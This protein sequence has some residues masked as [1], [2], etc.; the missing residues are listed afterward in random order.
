VKRK[1]LEM[2]VVA[3]VGNITW[4]LLWGFFYRVDMG[5]GLQGIYMGAFILDLGIF[6]A[7]L[8]YGWKQVRTADVR[9]WW[10]IVIAAL[11]TGWLAFYAALEHQGYDLPLGSNSAYLDNLEMSA[12]YLWYG[13]TLVDLSV[14][15]K[16]VAWSK[17]IGTLMV[18]VFVFM[19]YPDNAFVHTLA[20]MV[21]VMDV[22]YVVVLTHRLRNAPPPTPAMAPPVEPVHSVL[23]RSAAARAR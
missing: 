6:A 15:S 16:V 10:P 21:G 1:Q 18:T 7:A 2:P 19:A 23:G 22:A 11:A 8:L 12:L 3:A 17:G 14:L 9:R 5:W 20:V 4:E 13:L